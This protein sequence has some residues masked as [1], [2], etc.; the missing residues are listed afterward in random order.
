MRRDKNWV[1]GDEICVIHYYKMFMAAYKDN[2]KETEED[3]I[4]GSDN[5]REECS[6]SDQ[7]EDT[8]EGKFHYIMTASKGKPVALPPYV[9][10]D[11][12]YPGEPPL[13]GRGLSQLWL[14]STRT[15]KM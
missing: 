9:K 6:E 3:I 11:N 4:G 1:E 15:S 13:M 5:E 10:I 2:R 14:G 8:I 7:T 12:P